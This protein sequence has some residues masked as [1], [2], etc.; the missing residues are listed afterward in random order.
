M[1]KSHLTSLKLAAFAVAGLL[2]GS[3]ATRAQVSYPPPVGDWDLV[4]S[5]KQKGLAVLT[6]NLDGTLT[7][8]E[9]VRPVPAKTSSSDVDL[10]H[11][12]G[13]ADRGGGTGTSTN[14]GSTNI[15]ANTNILGSSVLTGVW[16][17]DSAGK[18]IGLIN[19]ISQTLGPVPVDVTNVVSFRAGVVPGSRITISTY[20]SG[21][22]NILRGKPVSDLGNLGGD[23][24]AAGKRDGLTFFEFADLLPDPG[25][26]NR[27][28]FSGIG[29][30]YTFTGGALVSRTKQIAVFALSDGGTLSV[31]TGSFSLVSRKGRLSGVDSNGKKVTYNLTPIPQP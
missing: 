7:G 24:Y 8:Y 11:P 15:I 3:S 5:G 14:G 18:V 13:E 25:L 28:D 30:G 17:Y 1:K 2:L 26:L 9:I 10:R 19:Q 16:N 12:G 6:F 4:Y 31:Y 23:F 22:K 21:G 27:Y 29:P 20:G